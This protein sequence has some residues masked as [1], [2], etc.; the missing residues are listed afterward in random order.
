LALIQAAAP[1][2]TDAIRSAA[3]E[4]FRLFGAYSLSD[5]WFLAIVPV[6]ILALVWGRTRFGRAKG[7]IGALASPTLPRSIVQR[8]VW[9]PAWLQAAA[10]VLV[11]IALA[12]PLRGSV[13]Y[14]SESEGVDIALVIDCSGSME[15]K[16][17]DPERSRLEVV[18][19][20]VQGFSVRRMTDREGAADNVAL[21][22]FAA[23]PKL[24]CPFTLDVDAITG[25]IAELK[26][27]KNRAEDGTALGVGL[28][29]A[30]A[31]LKE[32]QAKS[33]VV[34]LLTDGENNIDTITPADAA[35]LAAREKIKVYTV[36]A[37]R[38]VFTVDFFGRQMKTDREIDT[39]DL[40]NIAK[41]TGGH[42]FKARDKTELENVYKEIEKL[43]RTKRQTK[44]FSETYDLYPQ[45]LLPALLCYALAWLSY[46]TWARRL[47]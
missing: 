29:K 17:L 40:Q 15:A 30:V 24:L 31:V 18:K 16:D 9:I 41:Q 47:S 25:F 27:V 34:V 19:E 13:E 38:Y 33:K 21:I 26:P 32:T 12:R 11:A 35:D 4:R 22:Q 2:G 6:G 39:T 37:G 20:V 23:Y 7:R 44:R 46:S 42:F 43:E 3:E 14:A 36:F 1:A 5:P 8:F 10:L 45:F 28:A